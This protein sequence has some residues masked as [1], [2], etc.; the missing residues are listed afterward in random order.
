LIN[1][2]LL[3]KVVEKWPI[4]IL[5]L[6]AAIIIFI[7]FRMNSLE[8]RFFSVPLHVV[9]NE[10]LVSAS[11]I[12]NSVRISIRGESDVIQQI[13]ED[14]IEAFIDLGK[15]SN[16]GSFRVPV[17][18]RKRNSAL[19]ITPLEISVLPIEIQLELEQKV[20][21]SIPIA[22][23]FLGTVAQGFELSRQQLIPEAVVAEGPNSILENLNFFNTE[24]IDLDR[25]YS[26]FTARINIINN[27]PLIVI[28]GDKMIEY[29]G[30]INR[31]VRDNLYQE[32]ENENL[33]KDETD[34]EIEKDIETESGENINE[35]ISEKIHIEEQTGSDE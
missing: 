32:Q 23:V 29:R 19:G 31:I 15:F 7:F 14:D 9:A 8:T 17:Q 35:H 33:Q 6:A 1:K 4:K 21:R 13:M 34:I 12:S 18:I 28:Q 24:L 16:E 20:R 2:K 30:T 22:P 25:R 10:T 26:D 5:S 11:L 27:N 3:S